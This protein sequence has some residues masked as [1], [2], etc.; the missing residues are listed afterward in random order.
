MKA[1]RSLLVYPRRKPQR[2]FFRSLVACLSIPVSTNPSSEIFSFSSGPLDQAA[3]LV[4]T[5]RNGQNRLK[6]YAIVD[7]GADHCVFPRSFM[8]LVGLDPLTAPVDM[9]SGLGSTNVP[10]HYCNVT[11]DLGVINFQVYVGFTTGM[12]QFGNRLVRA[13]RIFRQV[14]NHLRSCKRLVHSRDA[15]K[16]S[17][18]LRYSFP[19]PRFVSSLLPL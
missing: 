18:A 4:V 16:P 1:T 12:D 7:S 9:T 6:C 19:A 5:L 11:L 10:T 2:C 8:Q 13:R 14:Q 17:Q 3:A 15:L